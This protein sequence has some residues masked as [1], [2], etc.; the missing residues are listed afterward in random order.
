MQKGLNNLQSL[1]FT[2]CYL[3]KVAYETGFIK[4]VRKLNGLD[5]FILLI[6]N[7]T[8]EVVSYNTMASSFSD[9]LNKSVFK[10]AL[11]KAM[12]KDAFVV[13][14]NR[15]FN[16]LLQSK[17]EL[18]NNKLKDK[19]NRIIIQDSTIVKLPKSLFQYFSGVKNKVTQVANS[20]LQL[21][22]DIKSNVFQLFSIDPYSLNDM[23]AASKLKICKGDLII[24]DRGY[25][26]LSEIKRI[27]SC[28]ADFIYRYYHGFKYHDPKTG[29]ALDIYELLKNK[30]R[31]KLNLRLAGPDGPIVTLIATR[32]C[33][34]LANQR[35]RQTKINAKNPPSEKLLKL[36]SWSIFF[37][38]IDQEEFDYKEI[39][40][41]YA[42]R[43]RIEIIF[44]SMKSHLNLDK[45]H[46]VPVNQLTFI[47]LGKM[48]LLLIITQFIY[49]RLVTKIYK[50]SKKI[51]SLLKLVRYL[52]DNFNNI[53]QL[54]ELTQ[55][56]NH[57]CRVINKINKYC[58]YDLRND[59]TN[60]QQDLE[61]IFLS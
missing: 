35:R 29:L 54:L 32:V 30:E 52:K 16:E 31:L 6:S 14:I 19:F 8:K 60:Y 41:L 22:L 15:I 53:N 18:S 12:S 1:G 42:L 24:R 56:K 43:W 55:N 44:K 50:I 40:E 34:E 10:Q 51:I 2:E 28:K 27:L 7:V 21:A 26:S 37:T 13:F 11:H 61:S 3:N 48:I 38:S 33:D 36:H 23:L 20:R 57:N 9:N 46:N 47:F 25:C 5:Y 59:R 58:T 49:S 45:I 39:A 17:L 4:R